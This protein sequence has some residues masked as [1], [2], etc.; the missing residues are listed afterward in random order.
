M[1]FKYSDD[2][3]IVTAEVGGVRL[4]VFVHPDKKEVPLDADGTISRISA[5]N[6][7]AQGHRTAKEEATARLQA[8]TAVI[9]ETDPE[10]VRKALDTVK[11]IDDKKL[12]DAG[13]VET[14]RA[15]ATKAMQERLDAAVASS[16]NA[17]NALTQE[18]DGF[19][20][21]FHREIIGGAFARSKFINEK[22]I[23]PQDMVE[24][25]FG[26]QIKIEN[27]KLVA[28]D[29]QG[30]RIASRLRPGDLYPD[31]DE[32]LEIIVDNYAHKER[33]LK[34]TQAS[35]GGAQNGGGAGA[36]SK[37]ITRAAYE[38]LDPFQ[39]QAAL[40]DKALVD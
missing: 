37:T 9:G 31:L 29:S 2:G 23:V 5:L 32:A 18:R 25:L 17:I 14:V 24:A 22:L 36:G 11:N 35:G 20:N 30:Q 16:T 10:S 40:K 34:G 6:A 7:E 27:D 1:P 33:I 39:R 3:Q 13:Q 8:L 26:Q 4:P 38:A 19:K 15:A 12:V 28:Y 21:K